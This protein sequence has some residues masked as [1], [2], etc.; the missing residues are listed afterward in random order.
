MLFS[1]KRMIDFVLQIWYNI[2]N[3]SYSCNTYFTERNDDGFFADHGG[4]NA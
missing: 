4:R 3:Y 2:Y 1:E